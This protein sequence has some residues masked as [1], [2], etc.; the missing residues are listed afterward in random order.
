MVGRRYIKPLV[1]GQSC[2][3]HHGIHRLSRKFV[4]GE[5]CKKVL[6]D[7]GPQELMQ[8]DLAEIDAP[9]VAATDAIHDPVL[10]I[11]KFPFLNAPSAREAH[12]AYC[13]IGDAAHP[14]GNV[15]SFFPVEFNQILVVDAPI[16]PF[17]VIDLIEQR[18]QGRPDR[19]RRLDEPHRI[20]ETSGEIGRPNLERYVKGEG[21]IRPMAP[22]GAYHVFSEGMIAVAA[23]NER[24]HGLH[25]LS[26]VDLPL[27]L[28]DEP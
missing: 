22:I 19:R 8:P 13:W 3:V 9:K 14:C 28:P 17:I 24:F 12:P 7:P 6:E 27:P 4:V 11:E 15:G 20:A 23:Q 5:A 2:L 18:V 10:K 1:R 26:S 25:G 16:D 21:M